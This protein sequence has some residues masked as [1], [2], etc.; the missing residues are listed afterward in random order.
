VTAAARGRKRARQRSGASRTRKPPK[1]QRHAWILVGLGL[2]L[3]LVPL[4]ALQVWAWLPGPGSGERR[5]V[6]FEPGVTASGAADRLATLGLV[7]SP[8]L[9]DWYVRLHGGSVEPGEHVLDDRLSAR[10]LFS[11]LA[12]LR[13]RPTV[14]FAIPE[15]QTHLLVAERLE[16]AEVSSAHAFRAAVRDRELLGELGI[17]GESAEG[18][19]FP[20]TYD[21]P[22]DSPATTLVHVMVKVFRGRFARAVAKRPGSLEALRARSFGEREIVTLASIVERETALDDEKPLIARVYLNRLSDAGFQPAKMLQA[23]PTAAYGC[24]LDPAAAPSCAGFDGHVTPALLR[25]PAN[26]YNT[27][28]HPGLPPGPIGNPGESALA[29]VLKPAASDYLFFVAGKDGRHKFSRTLAEHE[30]AI[31]R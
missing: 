12:R 18:Y 14:H 13:S 25:D 24:A 31:P 9:F 10:A 30:R 7:R 26:R 29:A 8:R 23:D 2:G 28:K 17:E 1:R 4:G 6:T 22:V 27:Y 3:L 11:R 16:Q 20:A 5:I 19:L 21:F 15:G